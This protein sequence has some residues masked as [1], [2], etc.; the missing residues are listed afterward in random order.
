MYWNINGSK[1]R[2]EILSRLYSYWNIK[3]NYGE[4]HILGRAMVLRPDILTNPF[5]S[6]NN[7]GIQYYK[8]ALVNF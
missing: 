4:L 2:P 1:Q 7:S 5:S 8:I 6:C 3:K